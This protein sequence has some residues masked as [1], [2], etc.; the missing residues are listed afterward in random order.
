[1]LLAGGA[2]V[3]LLEAMVDCVAGATGEVAVPAGAE[4]DPGIVASGVLEGSAVEVLP[5]GAPGVG[6]ELGTEVD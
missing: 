4:A 3:L 6:I 5:P 1:M 2:V